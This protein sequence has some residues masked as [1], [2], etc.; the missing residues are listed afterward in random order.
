MIPITEK[1]Q[2]TEKQV[3]ERIRR[4]IKEEIKREIK[5][6]LRGKKGK[7]R[8]TAGVI[9]SGVGAAIYL[10]F[11]LIFLIF[12][13]AYSLSPSITMIMA[14]GISL[15]GAIVATYKVKIGGIIVLISLPIAFVVGM[16]F[17]MLEP[18]YYYYQ[19]IYALQYL[20]FYP[21]PFI[22]F[23]HVLAGGIICLTASD[24]V[25]LRADVT[26]EM[27]KTPLKSP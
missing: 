23:V 15:T 16:L 2:S 12:T 26:Y 8:R 25:D 18:Y 13:G 14:G 6:E 24:E 11:G 7:S 1:E 5:E 10:V 17:R 9:I 22:H 3:E 19:W 27:S 4:E 20:M 21:I